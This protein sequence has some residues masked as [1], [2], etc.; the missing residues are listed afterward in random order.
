MF[1]RHRAAIAYAIF[2]ACFSTAHADSGAIWG[3]HHVVPSG[4]DVQYL[5]LKPK[6]DASTCPSQ[7]EQ[8]TYALYLVDEYGN[9]ANG[10]V[11]KLFRVPSNTV[12]LL[13]DVQYAGYSNLAIANPPLVPTLSI[14]ANWTTP[15]YVGYQTRAYVM[16][17]P[18]KGVKYETFQATRTFATGVAFAANNY[19]CLSID[20]RTL[21][22]S[23]PLSLNLGDE[24]S[25]TGS[26]TATIQGMLVANYRQGVSVYE[27]LFNW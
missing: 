11:G 6:I 10:G 25:G 8:S 20:A 19:I 16:A 27:P 15:V 4:Q 1:A 17:P 14:Y 3:Q 7:G 22:S 18:L 26:I 9:S 24:I 23:S 12:F 2:A 13:T 21:Q 5:T